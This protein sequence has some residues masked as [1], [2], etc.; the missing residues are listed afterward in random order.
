MAGGEGRV[1]AVATAAHGDDPVAGQRDGDVPVEVAAVGPGATHHQSLQGR[2][3]R[4]A[5]RVAGTDRGQRDLRPDRVEERRVLLATAV[6]RDLEHIGLQHDAAL[7]QRPLRVSLEIAG[8]QH[9][10]AMGHQAQH[11]GAVVGVAV[12]AV[13]RGRVEH[14]PG[15]L[16]APSYLPDLGPGHRHLALL[17]PTEQPLALDRR[18]V[19]RT[20]LHLTDLPPAQ[21]ARDALDVVGMQVR[22]HEQRHLLHPQPAQAAVDRARVGASVDHQNTGVEAHDVAVAL[23]HVARHDQPARWGP[24][25]SHDDERAHGDDDTDDRGGRHAAQR[26]SA[27]Q[28]G[29]G[30]EQQ[31]GQARARPA[32]RQRRTCPGLGRAGVGE[33]DQPP[34]RH[35]T[36]PREALREREE[37]RGDEGSEDAEDR[38]RRDRHHGEEVGGYGEQPDRPGQCDDDRCA[39]HLGGG[40]DGDGLGEPARQPAGEPVPPHRREHEQPCRGE[41]RQGEPRLGGEVR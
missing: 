38:R 27:E 17:Q 1:A 8:E 30:S 33:G 3:R 13:P 36:Q 19:E 22:Q 16:A 39:H 15:D 32:G 7:A 31:Q 34:G 14:L 35:E 11:D 29:Q 9:A 41:G 5:V 24:T 18:L 26:G 6:V 10:H 2:G 25:R 4:V 28:H 12:R 20:D 40:R 21:H 23:A 37:H